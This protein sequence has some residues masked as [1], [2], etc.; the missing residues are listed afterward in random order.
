MMFTSCTFR[1][2]IKSFDEKPILYLYSGVTFKNVISLFMIST[3]FI[4]T[5]MSCHGFLE[6]S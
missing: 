4:R 3:E 5:Q 1:E 2:I 6:N